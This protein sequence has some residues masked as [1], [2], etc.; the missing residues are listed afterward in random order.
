LALEFTP[1]LA[2]C[3]RCCF[4]R[5]SVVIDRQAEDGRRYMSRS[6]TNRVGVCRLPFACASPPWHHLRYDAIEA[7][8]MVIHRLGSVRGM[9]RADWSAFAYTPSSY[10][11]MQSSLPVR[12][13]PR[14]PDRRS[15]I[16]QA[17]TRRLNHQARISISSSKLV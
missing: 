12:V 8:C 5:C 9:D 13:T 6:W 1:Q 2:P 10:Q 3:W 15:R 17:P 11:H 4:W 14:A 16:R 7:T